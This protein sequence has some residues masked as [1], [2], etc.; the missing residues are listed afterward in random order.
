MCAVQLFIAALFTIARTQKQS[1]WLSLEKWIKMMEYCYSC[2]EL[3]KSCLTLLWPHGL[4]PARLLCSR[5][6]TGKNTGGGCHIPS[7]GDLPDPGI[8]PTPPAPVSGFLTTKPLG[9]PTVEYHSVTTK[10]K[11]ACSNTDDPRGW[12]SEWNEP[13]RDKR[14]M[15]LLIHGV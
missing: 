7:P 6:F 2:Y 4:Y 12:Y 14:H 1:K 10:N 9:K 13:E 3:A 15:V 5:D 11:T 8:K